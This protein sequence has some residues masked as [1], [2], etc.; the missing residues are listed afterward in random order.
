MDITTL[1][2]EDKPNKTQRRRL[3]LT[4]IRVGRPKLKLYRPGNVD[5]WQ[6]WGRRFRRGLTEEAKHKNTKFKK[7]YQNKELKELDL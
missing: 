7:V 6:H 2:P 5:I 1:V 3:L 4:L